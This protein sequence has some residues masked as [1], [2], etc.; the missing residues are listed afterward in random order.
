MPRRHYT[1]AL[2]RGLGYFEYRSMKVEFGNSSDYQ[3][4]VKIGRGKYS[5]VFLGRH[6]RSG[7][8][9]VL[10]VLKPIKD[11]R[12]NREIKIMM[13]LRGCPNVIQLLDVLHFPAQ[14]MHCLVLEY[15]GRDLR[16]T[17]R[18]ASPSA[19]TLRWVFRGI[20]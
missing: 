12:I 15:I 17:F 10:K 14:E 8:Q 18:K 19:E 11:S 2:D 5:E 4:E 9:V 1:A 6:V 7:T 13:A 16:T 20:L 3:A